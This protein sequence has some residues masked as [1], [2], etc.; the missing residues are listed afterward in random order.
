MLMRKT[1][2]IKNQSSSFIT[3]ALFTVAFSSLVGCSDDKSTK[4]ATP[5]PV[6]VF[7]VVTQE[8]GDYREFVAR[9]EAFKKLKLEPV[10]RGSSLSVTLTK[11]LRLK[12]SVIIA[13]RPV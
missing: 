1:A 7:N 4:Q 5:P 13:Y 9:T 3:T 11:D 12:R 6:S 8:V 10:L 2:R